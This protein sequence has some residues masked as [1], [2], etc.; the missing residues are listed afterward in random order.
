MAGSALL[1]EFPF[2]TLGLTRRFRKTGGSAMLR[3]M[4][5][6]AGGASHDHAGHEVQPR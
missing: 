1:V 4:K 2:Q 5:A 3:R 6:P